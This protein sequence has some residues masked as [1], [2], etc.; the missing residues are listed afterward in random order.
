MK[1]PQIIDNCRDNNI[2]V[3]LI[4]GNDKLAIAVLLKYL[5]EAQTADCTP[6]FLCDL[7]NKIK[8]FIIYQEKNQDLIKLPD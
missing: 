1:T 6:C 4:K 3:F 2:P 5:Y 7:T 8:E